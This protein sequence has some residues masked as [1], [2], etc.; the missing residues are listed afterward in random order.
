[1]VLVSVSSA[2]HSTAR[3]H[4]IDSFGVALLAS[5]REC[6]L[7]F[8]VL[9]PLRRSRDSRYARCSR[10]QNRRTGVI[11]ST[12]TRLSATRSLTTEAW[13][14]NAATCSAV[15]PLPKPL[16]KSRVGRD[17][18]CCSRIA[19]IPDSREKPYPF[20]SQ[21]IGVNARIR[22]KHTNGRCVSAMRCLV[23]GG[24]RLSILRGTTASIQRLKRILQVA[25]CTYRAK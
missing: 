17:N 13:P 1:M 15:H 5:Q 8:L 3:Q 9:I 11:A 6:R 19:M 20:Y 2:P 21:C 12:S 16:Y 7:S 4:Y 24:T 14:L 18:Y 25:A 10:S 23:Q 22:K